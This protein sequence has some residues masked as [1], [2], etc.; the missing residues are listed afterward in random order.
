MLD[1]YFVDI[2]S[3]NYQFVYLH[4]AACRMLDGRNLADKDIERIRARQVQEHVPITAYKETW[5]NFSPDDFIGIRYNSSDRVHR[6]L[7]NLVNGRRLRETVPELDDNH[8][9]RVQITHQ[10]SAAFTDRV[11]ILINHPCVARLQNVIQLGFSGAVY[12]S[13]THTRLEHSIGAYRNMCEYIVGLLGDHYNP[14]FFQLTSDE[15]LRALLVAALLHDVGQ[16]PVPHELEEAVR[17]VKHEELTIQWFDNPTKDRNG[18]TL[19]DIIENKS[20]GWGVRLEQVKSILTAP[21]TDEDRLFPDTI[22]TSMLASLIDGPIDVDKLDY[23]MRDSDRACL[24]Y[25]RLIDID[26]LLK[27][28]TIVISKNE[29]G[30]T[31]LTVGTYEKGQSAA[32]SMTFARYLLYQALY[33][34]RATRAP[35][36]MLRE[37]VKTA[38]LFKKGKAKQSFVDGLRT[39][40]GVTESP[41]VLTN[42]DV[43]NFVHGWADDSGKRLVEMILRRDYYKRVLTIH[44][45]FT[46]EEGREPLL[47]QFRDAVKREGFNSELQKKL[48]AKLD[49]HLAQVSGPQ[50]SSLAPERKGRVL[51]KLAEPN[52]VL[53]DCPR[54]PYGSREKLRF[55]SEPDRVLRN[56][57]TRVSGGDRVSEVW[58][59]VFFKLMQIASKGR[60]FCHPEIR[61]TLMAA[62]GPEG[63]REVLQDT[64]RV[65]S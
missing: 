15:D 26:R 54:P 3:Y 52:M 23:L 61:N 43:L 59:Q 50:A 33:W 2:V 24:P 65:F 21:A 14:L 8:I 10:G 31:V 38:S 64:I 5:L 12:P 7:D 45:E 51:D 9:E 30:R 41:R 42:V 35:R 40:L 56:Y 27:N 53:C 22:E 1:H 37:A 44:S 13:A 63:V 25:G 20:Y 32:E 11:R 18:Y 6:D 39:L 57:M 47:G 60:V 16:F 28:L 58:Q 19:R 17:D 62:L 34:H 49:Q 29:K 4:L 48:R 55:I 46:N 36:A